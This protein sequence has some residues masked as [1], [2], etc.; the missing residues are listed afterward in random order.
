MGNFRTKKNKRQQTGRNVGTFPKSPF[1]RELREARELI[2]AGDTENGLAALNQLAANTRNPVRRAKILLAI[3]D[4]ESRHSRH[5]EAHASFAKASLFASQ[6]ADVDLTL[7]AGIGMIRSLLRSLRSAEAMTA[8][9]QL[10]SDLEAAEKQFADIQNLTPAEL[11]A[12]GPITVPAQPPRLSV[13]LTKIATA[14]IELGHTDEAKSF[15]LKAIQLSPNGASRARQAL[16]KLALASDQPAV[17]ERYAREA[18][19]MGRFQAKTTAAWQFYLDA[20]ARQNL[21]PILEADVF[22]SFQ[23]H[24][25]GRIASSSTLSIARVLRAHGD[26]AWKEIASE[27][28]A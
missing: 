26:P 22:A 6:A 12:R 19:L 13:G 7:A 4:S 16:A 15:L 5:H 25:T 28:V 20:R 18:L 17:A 24:A 11:A 23:Q 2:A 9:A 27:A 1:S 21:V 10:L 14:F 3:G 8:A